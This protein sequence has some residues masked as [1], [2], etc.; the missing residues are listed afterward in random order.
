MVEQKDAYDVGMNF[1][2][3]PT[4]LR[5]DQMKSIL[6]QRRKNLARADALLFR[7]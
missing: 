5:R 6:G 1:M 7:V 3:F 4:S 2:P